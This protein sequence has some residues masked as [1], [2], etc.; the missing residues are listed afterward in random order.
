MNTKN[1]KRVSCSVVATLLFFSVGK[2]SFAEPSPGFKYLMNQPVSMLDWGVYRLEE[3]LSRGMYEREFQ[4]I[5][6]YNWETD[7]IIIGINR[8]QEN[9]AKNEIE[10][11]EKLRGTIDLIRSRCGIDPRTGTPYKGIANVYARYFRH[12]GFKYKSEPENL[13]QLLLTST[14]IRFYTYY[15][16]DVEKPDE[17]TNIQGKANLTGKDIYFVK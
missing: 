13:E 15:I 9:P 16:K 2:I 11:V 10:A 4:I 14:E 5:V 17:K 7:R 8:T 1:R 3:Y 6:S 12:A